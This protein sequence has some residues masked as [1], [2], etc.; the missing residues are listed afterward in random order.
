MRVSSLV[1]NWTRTEVGD[2]FESWLS[3][4]LLLL[5]V[6]AMLFYILQGRTVTFN[7]ILPSPPK[8]PER[9]FDFMF[10][11]PVFM[12]SLNVVHFHHVNLQH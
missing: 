5:H 7:I 6:A 2:G 12:C 3:Q 1:V 4:H 8:S 11:D 9:C 10:S